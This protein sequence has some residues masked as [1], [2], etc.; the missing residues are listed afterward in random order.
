MKEILKDGK[1]VVRKVELRG[2]Q[3]R[4]CAAD[5]RGP[6]AEEFKGFYRKEAVQYQYRVEVYIQ[7]EAAHG[8]AT[9][10]PWFWCEKDGTHSD[11]REE[12]GP[13]DAA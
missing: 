1:A 13:P 7:S 4:Q 5:P 11:Q 2:T 9:G 8:I 3:G 6:V 10:T 12:E